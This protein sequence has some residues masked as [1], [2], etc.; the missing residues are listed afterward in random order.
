MDNTSAVDALNWVQVDE[1][2]TPA[3]FLKVKGRKYRYPN[4]READWDILVGGKTVALV[5]FTAD[6]QVV[7]VRQFRPGPDAVL[8]ELPGGLVDEDET[9]ETAAARELL[10]ETGFE[11]ESVEVVAQTFLAAYAMHRR[12]AVVARGCRKVSDPQ[13]GQDEFVEPITMP[14]PEFV[15]HVLTG[16]LTDMDIALAG[17]VGAGVLK[18]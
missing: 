18:Q 14:I 7:L 16:Q 5:A 9:V 11:A 6:D 8:A 2:E 13:P 15:A 3:G 17:L 10:E 4:G 1:S 12:Y